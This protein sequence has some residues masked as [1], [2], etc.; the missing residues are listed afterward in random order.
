MSKI[1]VFPNKFVVGW[2]GGDMPTREQGLFAVVDATEAFHQHWPSDAHFAPYYIDG[3]EHIPRLNQR[4]LPDILA[5]G[6]NVLFDLVV[7]DVDCPEAHTS[8]APAPPH[9]RRGQMLALRQL[10][11]WK[12]AGY[13][14]TRGGYRL[15]WK[16]AEPLI[17]S[18]FNNYLKGVV[19]AIKEYGV[20]PDELTDWN[21]IYRLPNVVRDGNAQQAL[22]RMDNLGVLTWKPAEPKEASQFSGIE[23]VRAPLNI[24]DK[25]ESG[26]RNK[27]LTRIA[28]KYRRM[29]L[30]QDEILAG[31]QTINASRCEPP[32]AD[33]ELEAIA[34]SMCRYQPPE[35]AQGENIG[36]PMFQLGSDTEI[37]RVA[38]ERLEIADGPPLVF[39]RSELWKYRNDQGI[40]EAMPLEL[41]RNVIDTF[42]GE[43]I[44]AGVDRNG[45]PKTLTLKV[46]HRLCMNVTSRICDRRYHK[47]FFDTAKNGLTFSNCFVYANEAGVQTEQF[48]PSQRATAR[49]TFSYTHNLTPTRFIA[50]LASCFR[51][52]DD[53]QDKIRLLQ[54]F[55]GVCLL[56]CATRLQKGMIL[57]GTGA[58]GKSTIQEVIAALFSR[59]L[60]SAI[61]PQDMEQEYRRALLANSRLNVVNELPEADILASES[62]KAMIS[63]DLMT[64][65]H[66][67]QSPFEF[68][69]KAG[70]L[71]AANALPGVRDMS[72]GF[73]RRWLVVTFGRTFKK[74]EQI[75]GLAQDIIATELP[76]IA[77]WALRG[78]VTA[79]R[80]GYLIPDSSKKAIDEWRTEAD[81]VA[82]FLQHFLA[83][84]DTDNKEPAAKVYNHYCLWASGAGHRHLSAVKFAKRLVQLGVLKVRTKAGVVYIFDQAGDPGITLH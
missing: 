52:D 26:K 21:R 12:T 34:R 46:G 3:E 70:H 63:G 58:N 15:I 24:P 22:V 73:W 13:Y 23:T 48:S 10:P 84:E 20:C 33:E 55:I 17:P 11:W 62:V 75:P 38:C 51:D 66:I 32:V 19:A 71:F 28:G 77:S 37:A 56:G 54:Q 49:L 41:V 67:R 53:C 36:G 72:L 76:A 68:V 74:H 61:P 65:R 81:Q 69:P 45:E 7:L 79:L 44:A 2:S 30:S 39:D 14:E 18:T 64:G 59:K 27:L 42:D 29:G 43:K 50:T 78:A 47:G 60:I 4:A 80:D 82:A 25:I 16:L 83:K 9:W 31:L 57:V 40:W 1:V 8:G 35:S 6:G 5:K